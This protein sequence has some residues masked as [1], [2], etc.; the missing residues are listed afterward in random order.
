MSEIAPTPLQMA[1]L[2]DGRSNIATCYRQYP[3]RWF[4]ESDP[5]HPGAPP[6]YRGRE[7]RADDTMVR[8]PDHQRDYVWKLPKQRM[9]I[10]SAVLNFPIPS[11]ILTEDYRN[12][13]SVQDGQQRLETLWRYYN[14]MFSYEG[15][16]FKDLT[17]AEKKVFLDYTIP[18]TDITGATP[19]QE[20]D[21][22]DLLNQGVSLNHGEK[23]WNRRTKPLV[24]LSIRLFMTTGQGLIAP[25]SE[26]FGPYLDR[27][28]PRHNILANA[29]AY[30][31]GAAYGSDYIT[32]SYTKLV[33]MLENRL[34]PDGTTQAIDEGRVTARLRMLLDIYKAADDVQPCATA[35][36]KKGQWNIGLFSAYILHS[37]IYAEGD[38]ELLDTLKEG[39][40]AFLCKVR[41]H[42]TTVNLLYKG[43]AASKNITPERLEK[44]YENLLSMM[45]NGFEVGDDAMA[46]EGE[47][48]EMESGSEE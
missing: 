12:R 21:I 25:A 11:L 15:K 29:V 17:E 4:I 26:V 22:Y 35:T 2:L 44:G 18:V 47:E 20:E 8:I 46:E 39:W 48:E 24:A 5:R 45:A 19:E 34:R 38:A 30:V 3:L 23:F 1:S 16:Y 9:L 37:I 42:P 28:D 43:M 14:N 36:K 41:T 40:V 7:D 13:H 10:R 33:H 6:R 31:A 32:T 27:K